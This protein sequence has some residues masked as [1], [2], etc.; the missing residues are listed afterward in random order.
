MILESLIARFDVAIFS[1]DGKDGSPFR[2][3]PPAAPSHR[4]QAGAAWRKAQI[5]GTALAGAQASVLSP[6]TLSAKGVQGRSHRPPVVCWTITAGNSLRNGH[7]SCGAGSVFY[8]IV[9]KYLARIPAMS[10]LLTAE[11]ENSA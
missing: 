6:C 9:K 2:N 5:A 3:L 11:A 7:R 10:H 4:A 8:N 1:L